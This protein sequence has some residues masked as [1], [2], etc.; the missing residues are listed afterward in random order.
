MTGQAGVRRNTT[1]SPTTS[2]AVSRRL[3]PPRHLTLISYFPP[4]CRPGGAEFQALDFAK[5][6]VRKGFETHVVSRSDK[7]LPYREVV[8]GVRVHRVLYCPQPVWMRFTYYFSAFLEIIQL[9]PDLI[10]AIG[11]FPNCVIGS[12]S[13]RVLRRPLVSVSVDSDVRR[14]NPI[15]IS[16]FWK[17]ILRSSRVVIVKEAESARRLAPYSSTKNIAIIPNGIDQSRFR[18]LGR[19]RCRQLLGL[20][21]DLKVILY[22]GRLEAVK[23]VGSLLIA[24][25]KV[26]EKF[27][28]LRLL[29]VGG[30]PELAKLRA[31]ASKIHIEQVTDFVG[32]V[33]RQEVG[34]YMKA[35]D[36][37]VL[38]SLSEGSPNVVLEALAAGLPTLASRVGGTHNLIRHG[39]EGFLFETGNTAQ[40]THLLT[41]ILGNAQL[42]RK[43]S[44]NA[45]NRSKDFPLKQINDKILQLT[46]SALS[47]PVGH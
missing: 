29:I 19:R 31:T 41:L 17:F 32:E 11:F 23:N 20:S 14:G 40:M 15:V 5:H 37:L 13:S 22:V 24:F 28:D 25:S 26:L 1:L 18:G 12:V 38:P 33:S 21:S 36:L 16:L 42:K 27:Q 34:R 30:G 2:K 4:R 46:S 3:R 9:S 39:R 10:H 47:S 6:L 8:D 45:R 44:L 7:I 43:M 35:A